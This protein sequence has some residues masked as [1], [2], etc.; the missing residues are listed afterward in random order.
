MRPLRGDVAQAQEFYRQAVAVDPVNALARAFLASNLAASGH[1]A[2]AR[3]EYA[4]VIELNPSAPFSCQCRACVISWKANL[5]KRS[6]PPNTMRP[7]GH[8]SSSWRSLAGVK[9]ASRIRC[10]I[11]RVDRKNYGET[12]A[13]QI[14]EVY[15]YRETRITLSNGWSARASNATPACPLCAKICCSRISTVTR[16][17][18][19]FCTRWAWPTTN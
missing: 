1:Y 11:E 5:K 13:Y 8:S 12:A 3:A 6:R 2:E 7:N 10:G 16:A 14:A 15:G 17:G 4:R 9:N 18:M 19:H